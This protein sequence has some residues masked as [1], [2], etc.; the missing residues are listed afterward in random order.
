MFNKA[1]I[2]GRRIA[3]AMAEFEKGVRTGRKQSM[4]S[5]GRQQSKR[6]RKRKE[7]QDGS[8]EGD[9]PVRLDQGT[10]RWKKE[11]KGEINLDFVEWLRRSLVCT[12]GEP[13]DLAT[14]SSAIINGY[15]QCTKISALSSYKYILTYPT[16]AL[17]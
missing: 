9:G 5:K 2:K 8:K 16:E 13:K 6:V 12:S 4:H 10:H 3:V 14:L 1:I 15:G 7:N 17:M 11:I